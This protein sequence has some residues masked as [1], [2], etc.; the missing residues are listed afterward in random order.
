MIP[1]DKRVHLSPMMKTMINLYDQIYL[2]INEQQNGCPHPQRTLEK[3]NKSN[4]GNYDPS[5]NSYWAEYRCGR[6]G[7]FWH[8]EQNERKGRNE[9]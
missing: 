7:K 2:T 3:E 8:G 4:T 9:K 6:C 1:V 5:D